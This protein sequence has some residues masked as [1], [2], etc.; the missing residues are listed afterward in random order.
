M[1]IIVGHV[2]TNSPEPD[3]QQAH[4]RVEAIRDGNVSLMTVWHVSEHWIRSMTTWSLDEFRKWA[5]VD[6]GTEVR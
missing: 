2:Y 1:E 6:L 4:R 3:K 5:K